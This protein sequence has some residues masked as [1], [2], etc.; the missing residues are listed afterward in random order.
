MKMVY[1]KDIESRNRDN[2]VIRLILLTG[3]LALLVYIATAAGGP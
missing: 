1:A 3:L 2:L